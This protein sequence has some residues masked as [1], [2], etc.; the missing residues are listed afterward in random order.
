MQSNDARIIRGAALPSAAV[1]ALAVVI[2]AVAAGA[3]G[4]LGAALGALL[5]AGFFGLGQLALIRA[6]RRWPELFLGIGF[7]VYITQIGVLLGLLFLLRDASFLNGRAFGAGV[8]VGTVGWLVGQT[9]AN[10][11]LKTPYVEPRPSTG[12]DEEATSASDAS[13]TETGAPAPGGRP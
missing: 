9:R 6:S 10:F 1:G 7:L 13:A 5:A 2:A 3:E 4:A 8:L 11:T 12:G